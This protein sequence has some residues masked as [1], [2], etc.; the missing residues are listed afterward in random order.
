MARNS[1]SVFTSGDGVYDKHV[2]GYTQ[3]DTLLVLSYKASILKKVEQ[4]MPDGKTDKDTYNLDADQRVIDLK[5]RN[6]VHD[7]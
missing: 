5:A 3:G 2:G 6:K 1:P 4:K 7:S